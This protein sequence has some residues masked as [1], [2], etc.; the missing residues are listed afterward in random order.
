VRLVHGTTLLPSEGQSD[1]G[2]TVK[3]LVFNRL[4]LYVLFPCIYLSS[5]GCGTGT[6]LMRVRVRR[7]GK[8]CSSLTPFI[9]RT[10][11]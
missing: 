6:N 4:L 8:F 9:C 11:I 10:P 1:T 5:E 7:E 3:V 2:T